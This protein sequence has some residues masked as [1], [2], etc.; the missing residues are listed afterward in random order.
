CGQRSRKANAVASAALQRDCD[1]RARRGLGDQRQQMREPRAVVGNSCGCDW[2]PV[3][4]RDLY[5]MTV[6]M[7]VDTDDGIDYFCQHGHTAS[8]LLPGCGAERRHRPGWS[9]LAA[10]L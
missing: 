1:P 5:L 3:R 8:R 2:R 10:Y 6:P 9:H 7:R 4:I